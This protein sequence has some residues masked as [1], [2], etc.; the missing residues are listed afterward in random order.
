MV[1]SSGDGRMISSLRQSCTKL[2]KA[3]E[4]VFEEGTRKTECF[5]WLPT[6][7]KI[8]QQFQQCLKSLGECGD[9]QGQAEASAIF[10]SL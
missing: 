9:L 5:S 7:P 10:Y 8:K 3:G 6:V 2:K 1:S 4:K